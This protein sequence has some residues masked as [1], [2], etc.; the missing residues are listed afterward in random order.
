MKMTDKELIAA[1]EACNTLIDYLTDRPLARH[2]GR[3]LDDM[4]SLRSDIEDEVPTE[5]EKES[6]HVTTKGNQK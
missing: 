6:A 2:R 1:Y 3:L 4:K 5:D